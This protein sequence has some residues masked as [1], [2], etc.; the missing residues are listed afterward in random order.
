MGGRLRNCA[1]PFEEIHP[2]IL[3]SKCPIAQRF[4]EYVHCLTPHQ[5]RKITSDC[6]RRTGVV[7][8]GGKRLVENMVTRCVKCRRLRGATA[9]QLMADLPMERVMRSD[10]FDH[11]GIDV[12]GPYYVHD[13]RSTRRTVGSK[14]VFVLLVNCL[15][16]RAIHLEPLENMDTSAMMNALRR[17]FSIRGTCKSITSDHGSNFLGV[18]SQSKHF[19]RFQREIETRGIVW[20][21]NPVGASHYGGPYERK[22]GSVRRVLEAYLLDE[23]TPLSRDELHTYLMEAA[24]VVNST[25]LYVSYDHPDEPSPISPQMLI[26]L[27]T[28]SAFCPGPEEIMECDAFAYGVKRWRR[29]QRLADAFWDRW[30]RFYL[31]ELSTRRKWTKGAKNLSTGD[32]VLLREKNLPRCEWRLAVVHEAIPGKDLKVRRVTIRLLDGRGKVAITE[33]A[34]TDLVLLHSPPPSE[35]APGGV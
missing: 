5:G 27:K 16:S 31:Q 15:A 34:I 10:L 1:S 21:F 25:P 32:V 29:V 7:I 4:A 22:I 12:F 8:I 13:G 11:I 2:I 35:V 20:H 6:I 26:T 9:S 19:Q 30:Q 3:S 18:V 14:K 17:F 24:A 33:R 23:K 28:P